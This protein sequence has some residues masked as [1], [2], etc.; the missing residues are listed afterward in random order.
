MAIPVRVVMVVMVL[1]RQLQVRLSHA[2]V[3]AVVAVTTLG[4]DLGALGALVVVALVPKAVTVALELLTQAVVVVVL[5]P[6]LALEVL[7]VQVL[8]FSRFP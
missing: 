6:E 3:V 5:E 7:A 2:P 1:L 8:L 4:H